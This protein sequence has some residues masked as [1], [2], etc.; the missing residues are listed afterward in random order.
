MNPKRRAELRK[1]REA[2]SPD[3]FSARQLVV[4]AWKGQ[5]MDPDDA[6]CIAAAVNALVPLLD[7]LD[8]AEKERERY[9][10]CW[11]EAEESCDEWAQDCEDARSERDALAKRVAELEHAHMVIS[12]DECRQQ[13]CSHDT[14][15]GC[16]RAIAR[17]ALKGYSDET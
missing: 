3:E 13:Y 12:T 7:A 10:Q 2:A 4:D 8:A 9:R 14:D 17:C 11:D 16:P 1:L 6:E 5:G 15:D